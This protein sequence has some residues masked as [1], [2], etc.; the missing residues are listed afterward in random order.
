MRAVTNDPKWEALMRRLDQRQA[1]L[2]ASN[3]CSETLP[4]NGQPGVCDRCGIGLIGRRTRWC[5]MKCQN[6]WRQQHDWN[7][8]RN[9]AKRRDG[10]RCVV[11]RCGSADRLEVNHIDPRK[12]RGYGFGCHNHLANLETLCHQHH[13]HVTWFQRTS[14]CGGCGQPAVVCLCTERRLCGCRDLHPIGGGIG[15]D[16]AD[17]FAEPVPVPTTD[18]QAELF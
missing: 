15:V 11:P 5:S 3:E 9:A 6:E 12:G 7:A 10:H 17:M 2:K 8:A 4:H 1:D 16:L 13:L 14:H 18:D